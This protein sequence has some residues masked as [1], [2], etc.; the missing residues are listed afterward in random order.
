M[1]KDIPL[2]PL[3]LS[4]RFR[5]GHL[6]FTTE[7]AATKLQF[8]EQFLLLAGRWRSF[9]AIG[10]PT[11]VLGAGI[12]RCAEAP[13]LPHSTPPRERS[14]TFWKHTL[15]VTFFTGLCVYVCTRSCVDECMHVYMC[16]CIWRTEVN[17]SGLLSFITVYTVF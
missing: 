5:K 3:C 14:T 2:L 12:P 6:A 11:Q 8:S 17:L 16:M 4:L 1:G 13:G 9:Q 15:T 7:A 10:S